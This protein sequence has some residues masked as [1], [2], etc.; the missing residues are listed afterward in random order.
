MVNGYDLALLETSR[1]RLEPLQADHARILFADLQDSRLY[2][3]FPQDPPSSVD[4]LAE[5]YE[6]LQ[7]RTSPDG[8]EL[9]LNWVIRRKED[10]AHV[11]TVEATVKDNGTADLAYF[12][13]SEYQRRGVAREACERVIAW[14]S[15][16]LG[17]RTVAATIDTRNA[18]SI[19]LVESMGFRRTGFAEAADVFKGSPS[20]EFRY[21]RDLG[22]RQEIADP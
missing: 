21:A 22:A 3:Y 5:R 1:L 9:W 20:D 16:E 12:V 2:R 10:G 4:S 19:A 13:F 18:A 14:L 11:G 15:A 6:K 7:S 8:K 17:V